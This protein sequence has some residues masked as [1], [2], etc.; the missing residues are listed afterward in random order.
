MFV[1]ETFCTALEYGLPPTAGW[2]LGIDRLTMFLTDSNNIKVIFIPGIHLFCIS[3][4]SLHR[5]H[6]KMLASVVINQMCEILVLL[7]I[8]SIVEVKMQQLQLK[9]IIYVAVILFILL[10]QCPPFQFSETRDNFM[11]YLTHCETF[12]TKMFCI[13]NFRRFFSSLQ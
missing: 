3:T 1:D 12:V 4:C 11:N 5:D 7:A 9:E 8:A 10:L 6:V 2:G 13:L